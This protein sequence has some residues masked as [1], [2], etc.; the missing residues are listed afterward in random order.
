VSF[1]VHGVG[2]NQFGSPQPHQLLNLQAYVGSCSAA[3]TN[4][5]L[6]NG[7]VYKVDVSLPAWLSPCAE[8]YSLEAE[9]EFPVSWSYNGLPVGPLVIPNYGPIIDSSPSEPMPMIVWVTW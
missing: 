2:T 7:F 9:N 3:V 4:A 6:I 1:F 5:L 8:G